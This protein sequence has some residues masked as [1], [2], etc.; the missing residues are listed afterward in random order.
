MKGQAAD[1]PD[2]ALATPAPR[3][4]RIG[5]CWLS[6][7]TP[8]LVVGPPSEKRY[9]RAHP[10]VWLACE[11]SL[12]VRERDRYPEFAGKPWEE[13]PYLERVS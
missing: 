8:F 1:R 4:D 11:G 7:G 2:P 6:H 5:Q 13:Q 10:V 9:G 12:A 3:A